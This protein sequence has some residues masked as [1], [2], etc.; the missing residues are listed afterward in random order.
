MDKK[1]RVHI[2][3]EKVILKLLYKKGV[4]IKESLGIE[5]IGWDYSLRHKKKRLRKNSA[6]KYIGHRYI[7][8]LH[9]YWFDYWGEGDSREFI[10]MMIDWFWYIKC[11]N[12]YFDC[13]GMPKIKRP[14]RKDLITYLRSLPNVNNDFKINEL[15]KVKLD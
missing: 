8:V 10:E 12:N 2:K 15:L 4:L 11:D 7:P 6:N 1:Q 9:F 3:Q 13:R 14:S 5:D